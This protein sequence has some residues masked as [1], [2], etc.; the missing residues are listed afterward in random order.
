MALSSGVELNSQLLNGLSV[1]AVFSAMITVFLWSRRRGKETRWMSQKRLRESN[2]VVLYSTGEG[3][4]ALGGLLCLVYAPTAFDEDVWK[5][6]FAS[7][8]GVG[9]LLIWARHAPC[10]RSKPCMVL[11]EEGIESALYGTIPWSDVEDV[12]RIKFTVRV[13]E[14]DYLV[15]K[16]R[17]IEAARKSFFAPLRWLHK[18]G[19]GREL[20]FKIA[21]MSLPGDDVFR[22]AKAAT[23]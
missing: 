14:I 23:A 17:D 21:N 16:L 4:A 6:V 7:L 19:R 3:M 22:Y 1:L 13:V 18:F 15:L 2:E 12:S 20:K 11:N 8:A 10:V 9:G 5:G